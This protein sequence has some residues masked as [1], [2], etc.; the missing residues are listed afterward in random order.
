MVVPKEYENRSLYHFT[1]IENL[2]S[3]LK[4]GLLSQNEKS[5]LGINH[6][7]ISRQR[8]QEKRSN[9]IITC[10]PGGSVHD[11]VPLFFCKKSPMLS[12]VIYNKKAD[13]KCIIYLEFPIQIMDKYEMVFSDRSANEALNPKFY[14][15]TSNIKMLNW[16]VIDTSKWND[17]Y[18]IPGQTPIAQQKQCEALFYKKLSLSSLKKVVVFNEEARKNVCSLFASNGYDV[19]FITVEPDDYYYMGSSIP[20]YGPHDIKSHF[21]DTCNYIFENSR[22]SRSQRFKSLS[23]LL[24]ALRTNMSCLPETA[25]L[26]GLKT[27]NSAHHE[28]VANHTKRVVSKLKGIKEFSKLDS[29][30]TALVE[31][32]AYLHDIGKGPKERLRSNNGIQKVNPDYPVNG[33]LMLKRIF[34]EEIIPLRERSVRLIC[35]LVCYHDLVGDIVTKGRREE[36]LKQIVCDEN[37]LNMLIA[38]SKADMKSIDPSWLSSNEN[39]IEKLRSNIL[40][41][42]KAELKEDKLQ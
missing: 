5:K 32:A 29:V 9:T 6:K 36:E 42:L 37:E 18:D 2:D 40:T 24:N 14:D 27:D 39:D 7:D 28:D 35:K 23:E 16:E 38:I 30:D 13:Q 25:E 8:I 15:D 20:R 34:T 17:E 33:L 26:I 12:S 10:G 31:V 11:Y 19:P 22:N 3:I 41:N 4:H 21:D 1:H